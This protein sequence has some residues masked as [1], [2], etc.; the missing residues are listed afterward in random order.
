MFARSRLA[1]VAL[2]L[3]AAVFREADATT[4]VTNG[5]FEAQAFMTT[6]PTGNQYRYVPDDV[7]TITGWAFASTANGENSYLI[8]AGPNYGTVPEGSYALRL[9]VGDGIS[10]AITPPGAGSYVVSMSTKDWQV[11]YNNLLMTIG[12]T[13][14]V[15]P[16]G[17]TG[18]THLTAALSGAT[19]LSIGW[20]PVPGEADNAAAED[21]GG[22]GVVVDAISV[23]AVPEPA[24]CAM[25]LAGI[26]GGVALWR[27]RVTCPTTR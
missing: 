23:T 5:G 27:R 16:I 6:N 7:A 18:V 2:S 21:F 19:T 3:F 1:I 17:T 10:Q 11:G 15:I 20:Q 8:A 9:S 12:G 25:A 22:Q 4:L 14:V 24:G 26:A 13:S